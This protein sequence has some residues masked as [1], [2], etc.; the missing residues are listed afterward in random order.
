MGPGALVGYLSQKWIAGA[1]VQNWW[2]FAGDS[3]RP[4][5]RGMNL[6]PIASWLLGDGWSIGYSGNILA[7]WGSRAND[8]FT[9]PL[10]VSVSKVNHGRRRAQARRV[11]AGCAGSRRA[12]PA[13]PRWRSAG[14]RC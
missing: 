1:L 8:V 9:V 3:D 7:N 4:S 13:R 6:Q 11:S 2:S 12:G 14:S 5:A 10:G